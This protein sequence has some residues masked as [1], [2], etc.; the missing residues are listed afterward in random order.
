MH[1]G[2]QKYETCHFL[3]HNNH[4]Y[5]E[6]RLEPSTSCPPTH[7]HHLPS[8]QNIRIRWPTRNPG[9]LCGRPMVVVVPAQLMQPLVPA[10]DNLE[11]EDLSTIRQI[12]IR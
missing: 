12:N 4:I 3:Y 7:A 9:G 11:M 6:R 2:S 1:L 10:Q 5:T 8:S